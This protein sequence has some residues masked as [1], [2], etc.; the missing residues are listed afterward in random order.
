M[1]TRIDPPTLGSEPYELYKQELL[2]WREVTDLRKEKQGVVIALSLPKNDKTQIREKVF[3]QI[4]IDDLKKEDGLDILI[5]FLDKHLKKDDLADSLEKFG[6]FEDFQRKDGMTISEYIASFDS[7]YRKI[8]KLKMTL[9]PEILAFKLL[10]KA[11]IS[12]E[13]TML[14]LTGMNY[15]N[16]STL[17]EEAMNSLKKFKGDLTTGNGSSSS[18]IKLEPAFLAENEEA[19]LAAGYVKQYREG[20]GGK[21]GRGGYS[22]GRQ[23][24][25][26]NRKMNPIGPDGK[27]LTCRCC[28][29]FRHLVA[30]CP[31]SWESI[32]KSSGQK[33][34][35][36]VNITEDENVVLFTGYNKGDIVQL[37]IDAHNCAVLDSAC[38][39]TVC[40]KH[41]LENYVNSLNEKEKLKIKQTVG[42]RTFKFGGGER[43]KSTGEYNLPAVVAGKEVFIKTD[44][45]E[46]DIPLLLSRKAM[47]T[48][49]VKMDLETDTAR[50]FGKDVALNLTTSGHYCIPIDRA[51]KMSVEQ[52]FAVNF[53]QMDCKERYK[54]LIKLHRQFAHPPLKKLKALLQDAGQWKED[55]QEIL[56]D[57]GEKCNL[58]KRYMKTPPR[59][60][61]GL[62][63]ASK[64]NEKVAMDLKQWN[65][66]WILHII[67]IWSRYTISIFI[68]RKRSCDV[69]NALMQGWIAVFGV[70]EAILTDNGGEFSSD[71]MREVMSI[72]DVQIITTA[73]DSPFQ[74]GLCERVHAV[75]DMMLLKLSEENGKTNSQTLLCWANMAR[76]SLQMWNGFSSHQLIFGKNPNL[77]G[78]MTDKLPALDGI[79]SSEAFAQHLNVLHEARKAYI[80]TESNERVRRALRTKV[81]AAEQIF[82]NGEA[83]FYKREGKERWL[84]PARVVFQDGKVVFIRHGGIFVRVCPNRLTKIHD[85]DSQNTAEK[86]DR[87]CFDENGEARA[88][89]RPFI[90]NPETRISETIPAPTESSE[91][92]HDQDK[93]RETHRSMINPVQ[94]KVNDVIRY[95]VNDEWVTGTIMGRAGKVTG[96][97]KTWYN[98]RDGNNEDRSIDLGNIEWEM[99]HDTEINV[100]TVTASDKKTS[101]KTDIIVAKENELDKLTQFNTYEEVEASG[102]EVLSTRWVITTKEGKTKARLVVRGFEE[103]DIEIPRDSP[104]VSKGAMRI[105]LSVVAHEQ[106]TVKTTDIKSAF[107]QGKELDREIYIRPPQESRTPNHKIWKLKHGLYGLKDGARQFYESVKEELLKLGFTQCKLDPAVFYIHQN[108]KLIGMICCHVD[109]FLHAGDQRFEKLIDKLR[110]RFSAGKMEEKTFKYIGF[111]IQQLSNKITLDHS[112]YINNMMNVTLDPGRAAEKNELLNEKEQ[113]LYRK[114]IGQLNWAVQ[115]SR[116]DMAYEM[117][118]MSTKLK[119]AKV[120]DLVRAIK[121]INQL[122]DIRSFMTFPKMDKTRGLKIVI[123][124]D[125]SLGNINEGTGSTGAFIIWLIDSTGQ[126]CPIA[127]N[128]KKIK[129]VVRSTLAAEMLS[130]EEGLEAGIY[131]R[132]MLE[133][134]LGLEARTIKIEAFVDNKSVIEA[135]LSTRMVEDKRLRV[136]VAAIQE[137]LK[138]H[139]IYQI[140]WIPGHLQLANV[141]TKQGA[142]GFQLL[143]VLQSGNMLPEIN[144]H[145]LTT[146]M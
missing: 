87:E 85:T 106:W 6:E 138:L 20:K 90:E 72:L 42:Q 129:R 54:T 98:V 96:K 131:Y 68:P 144:N 117:I 29:S 139:D 86:P 14:V 8:E 113:T 140:Q 121:K 111:Q 124:T 59:P 79:T 116:P 122:K 126:C 7:R 16:K 97:Y 91:V 112:N 52:V 67:D 19:L 38:S 21:L 123:F 5:A 15:A 23:G 27:T 31:H 145:K 22:R 13:E 108:K 63:M 83:V 3:D 93:R 78:I 46:S 114:L 66:R 43:L 30:E 105:F 127:W 58:C 143:K 71:E 24:Q 45:V 26:P 88:E 64:F 134:V 39:S 142:S 80:E 69:I 50:I 17:Y 99:I 32:P 120:G 1:A 146:D 92:I 76:N 101:Q 37:G 47:K 128:A 135:L 109:D 44:V 28:G 2:A 12:K 4:S 82:E 141:M 75:T 130:L 118:A 48:A 34:H 133:D 10:R 132:H 74:N 53:E 57:I 95:K 100:T 81:R 110:E 89:T 60:A 77:P 36:K 62:P 136:D 102:Q 40:G 84:G 115:G 107:L 137:S 55:Y 25:Q 119:Q 65:G 61:V 70:M 56:E 33:K 35:A 9:P 73:A 49:G 11:N 94:V 103:K 125:A 41:W 104:T 18:G 51:E